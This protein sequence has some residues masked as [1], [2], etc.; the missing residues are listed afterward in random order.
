LSSLDHRR[1]LSISLGNNQLET[2]FPPLRQSSLERRKEKKNLTGPEI[3]LKTFY[4][5]IYILLLNFYELFLSSFTMLYSITFAEM[6]SRVWAFENNFF[7]ASETSFYQI[8]WR[9]SNYKIIDGANLVQ[10]NMNKH[11]QKKH[12]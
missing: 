3:F 10:D 8:L 4:F 9:S 5:W 7:F 2:L 1:H 11:R 6:T 12:S